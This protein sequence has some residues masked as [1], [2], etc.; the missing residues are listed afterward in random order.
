MI[1]I[2]IAK[3]EWVSFASPSVECVVFATTEVDLLQ[4][5]IDRYNHM[6]VPYYVQM[7]TADGIYEGRLNEESVGTLKKE[8]EDLKRQLVRYYQDKAAKKETNDKQAII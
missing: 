6:K 8:T 1:Y 7:W 4:H 3:D 2:L 5:K